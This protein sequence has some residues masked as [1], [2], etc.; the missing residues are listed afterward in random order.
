MKKILC[1][2]IILSFALSLCACSKKGEYRD[3]VPCSELLDS[4]EEQIPVDMGYES[5]DGDHIKYNFE[6]TELDDDHALRY[7]TASENINEIGVFHAP[8]EASRD[9]LAEL[10][11]RYLDGLLEEKGEFIASYA[12][13]ELEKL[14]SAEVKTFGNY[15]AYAILSEDDREVFFDTVEKML[16]GD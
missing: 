12:P 3:D 16:R 6:D 13:K 7:S 9:G 14:R 15:V 11:E 8:D 4:A 5:F 1:F 10:T 2:A